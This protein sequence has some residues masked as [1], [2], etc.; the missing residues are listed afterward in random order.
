MI[1]RDIGAVEAKRFTDL[2]E[3]SPSNTPLEKDMDTHN[4]AVGI[5]IGKHGGTDV[6]LSDACY[7]ALKLGKLKKII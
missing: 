2:H 3:S 5:D 6:S 7:K 4:N 1:S